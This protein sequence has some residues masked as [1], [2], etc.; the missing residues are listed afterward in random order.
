MNPLV[1]HAYTHE[2]A[3]GD[4][5]RVHRHRAYAPDD[6]SWLPQPVQANA[7]V[8]K[9]LHGLPRCPGTDQVESL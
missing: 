6:L 1:P 7:A 2:C 3:S 4:D 5:V 8:A 9:V